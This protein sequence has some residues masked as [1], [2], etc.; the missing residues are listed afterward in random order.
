M[1]IRL[2]LVGLGFLTRAALLPA[3]SGLDGF[4][5]AAALDPD[6]RARRLVADALPGAV[7]TDDEDAFFGVDLDAVHVATPNHLHAPV[8]CRALAQHRAVLVDKPLAGTVADA[9]AIHRATQHATVPLLVGYMSRFN[10]NNEAVRRLVADGAIGVPLA[11]NATHLG[12]RD[13]NW[14]NYRAYSGLGSAADLAIY[15]LLT[16]GALLG[17]PATGC[18]AVAYPSGDPELTDIYLDATVWFGDR[19]LHIESSFTEA[20]EV[21]V[22]RYSVVGSAGVIVAVDTWAM[23]GGGS[24]L[25]CDGHGR[26]PVTS[27]LVDPYVRQYRLLAECM[28]GRPV[29][30]EVGSAQ[31][32][33]D[34][35]VLHRLDRSAADGGRRL[36]IPDTEP[37]WTS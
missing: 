17:P 26:R 30:A 37:P 24:V 4:E 19:R 7:V 10:A 16:A 2:G 36:A 28:A 22:S 33:R 18:Q 32:L 35:A 14:R 29:P 6:P 20:P 12:H 15:P 34:V 1:T 8:T 23:S 13:G 11:M 3:L 21:G 5:V 25:L 27:P 9:L 31:G